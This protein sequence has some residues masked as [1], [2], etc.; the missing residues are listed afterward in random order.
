VVAIV[1]RADPLG[2]IVV[3]AFHFHRLRPRARQLAAV[4]V[5][6]ERL[7]GVG[8]EQLLRDVVPDRLEPFGASQ[9]RRRDIVARERE[10]ALPLIAVAHQRLKGLREPVGGRVFRDHLARDE[11]RDRRVGHAADDGL[12]QPRSFLVALR[13]EQ[14]QQHLGRALAHGRRQVPQHR[15]EP[16]R[17]VLRDDVDDAAQHAHEGGGLRADAAAGGVGAR[18][19]RRH[20]LDQLVAVAREAQQ[21][22]DPGLVELEGAALQAVGDDAIP[23]RP[24]AAGALAQHLGVIDLAQLHV[25]ARHRRPHAR[26]AAVGAHRLRRSPEEHEEAPPRLDVAARVD[27]QVSDEMTVQERR[28]LGDRRVGAGRRPLVQQQAVGQYR[29]PEGPGLCRRRRD[30]GDAAERGGDGR[31]AAGIQHDRARGGLARP[32]EISEPRRFSRAER[33]RRIDRNLASGRNGDLLI[34]VAHVS[35]CSFTNLPTHRLANS[36]TH[37]FVRGT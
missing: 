31:M 19:D 20:E 13:A 7:V 28:Q 32:C 34:G 33:C 35:Q 2:R 10:Q 1:P 37:Q 5:R 15:L 26:N 23:H 24:V 36:P 8:R 9:G 17:V 27:G 21:L 11:A 30:V 22:T 14:R 4:G 25:A 12:H 29:D 18:L 3:H 6:H 16:L